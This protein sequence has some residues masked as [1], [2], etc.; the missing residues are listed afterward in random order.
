MKIHN[1]HYLEYHK[2]LFIRSTFGDFY[3]KSILFPKLKKKIGK[4]FVDVGC[5]LGEILS[6]GENEDCIGLDINPYNIDFVK[7]NGCK[8][9]LI[10]ANGEFP[11]GNNS[12]S[13]ILCD[14]VL[15][16]IEKPDF[17]LKEISRIIKP[18]GNILFGVPC[19]VGFRRDN[20]HKIFYNKE[21]LISLCKKYNFEFNYSFYFPI[22]LKMLGKF[23]KF[24]ALY[25]GF[26][27]NK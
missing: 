23:L 11:L 19:E 26:K 18:N 1:N 24:Q 17:L 3:R 10:K 16:H 15:E 5:G 9:E 21:S 22:P 6:Y 25:I 13:S 2:Y 14:Q 20:D 4:S 7:K 12:T 8:A 27:A